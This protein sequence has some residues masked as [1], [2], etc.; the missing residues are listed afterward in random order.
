MVKENNPELTKRNA[1]AQCLRHLRATID[2]LNVEMAE[3]GGS[4]RH[5]IV[6]ESL[7]MQAMREV[8]NYMVNRGR[9]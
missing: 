7:C 2:A 8:E 3:R 9:R 5:L 4:N 1:A 6:C